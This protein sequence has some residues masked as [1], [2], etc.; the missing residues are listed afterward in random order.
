METFLN[1]I[2]WILCA[3]FLGVIIWGTVGDG[4][5]RYIVREIAKD[6]KH[7]YETED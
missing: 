5:L 6:W 2:T 7:K 3:G 4:S 1:I